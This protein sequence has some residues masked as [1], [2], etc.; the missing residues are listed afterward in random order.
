MVSAL[1]NQVYHIGYYKKCFLKKLI[2]LLFCAKINYN[3]CEEKI[4][5]IILR[6]FY[7]AS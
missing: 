1:I 6:R 4:D 2:S 7:R 3:L 5:D